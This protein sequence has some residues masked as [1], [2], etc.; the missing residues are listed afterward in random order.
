[1]L[2]QTILYIIQLLL[3]G[4]NL[5]YQAY[6]FSGDVDLERHPTLSNTDSGSSSN[7]SISCK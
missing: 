7:S 6:F 3:I 5:N 4:K 1:M 2:G